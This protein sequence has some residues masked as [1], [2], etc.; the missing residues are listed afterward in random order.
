[1][2]ISL[3][4]R[5]LII[6]CSAPL[7]AVS[8]FYIDPNDVS[9]PT[10]SAPVIIMPDEITALINL[11]RSLDNVDRLIRSNAL[12]EAAAACD[13]AQGIIPNNPRSFYLMGTIGLARKDIP[14]AAHYF[15]KGLDY[16]S[17]F[18]PNYDG[19]GTVHR[20]TQDYHHA[21]LSYLTAYKIRTNSGYYLNLAGNLLLELG[22]TNGAGK[23]FFLGAS[24]SDPFCL[25]GLGI[26]ATN[27]L[28][29]L[30]NFQQANERYSQPAPG[31]SPALR[32][33]YVSGAER[34]LRL[35][36]DARFQAY[37]IVM[38]RELEKSNYT[39]A[40]ELGAQACVISDRPEARM[41]SARSFLGLSRTNDAISNLIQAVILSPELPEPRLALASLYEK[42]GHPHDA[43]DTLREGIRRIKT[44]ASLY[45]DLARLLAGVHAVTEADTVLRHAS[46]FGIPPR[47]ELNWAAIKKEKGDFTGAFSRL[48]NVY[49]TNNM[50]T[51]QMNASLHAMTNLANTHALLASN[52][53]HK[54]LGTIIHENYTGDEEQIRLHYIVSGLEGL[55]RSNEALNF[56]LSNTS[57]TKASMIVMSHL[58]PLFQ[59]TREQLKTVTIDGIDAAV[60]IPQ[61][62]EAWK[63]AYGSSS[64]AFQEY[65]EHMLM[66]GEYDA[67]IA[68]TAAASRNR[69]A[70]VSMKP[71]AARAYTALGI[72]AYYNNRSGDAREL[73]LKALSEDDSCHDARFF[74]NEVQAGTVIPLLRNA[75]SR[76]DLTNVIL[77]QKNLLELTPYDITPLV[78]LARAYLAVGDTAAAIRTARAIAGIYSDGSG[79]AIEG[80]ALFAVHDYY[81]A[82]KLYAAARAREPENA[83]YLMKTGRCYFELKRYPEALD[84]LFASINR[85]PTAERWFYYASTH[86]YLWNYTEAIDSMEKALEL[87]P[88]EA[89]YHMNYGIILFDAGRRENALTAFNRALAL[90]ATLEDASYY[91][92]RTLYYLNRI[93]E[94]HDLLQRLIAQKPKNPLYRFAVA[95]I[96]ET[97]A[98]M[99]FSSDVAEYINYAIVQLNTCIELCKRGRD[100]DLRQEALRKLKGLNPNFHVIATATLPAYASAQAAQNDTDRRIIYAPLSNGTVVAYNIIE[101][102]VLWE[103]KLRG[104]ASSPVLYALDHV[105]FGTDTGVFYILSAKTGKTVSRFETAG[106]ITE[107]PLLIPDASGSQKGVNMIALPSSDGRIYLIQYVESEERFNIQFLQMESAITTPLTYFLGHIIYGTATGGIYSLNSRTGQ[108]KWSF[109]AGGRFHAPLTAIDGYIYA[110]SDDG[111][112]YKLNADDGTTA[113]TYR[114]RGEGITE[115]VVTNG[116]CFFGDADGRFTVLDSS[117]NNVGYD[118]FNG[119]VIDGPV[120]FNDYIIIATGDGRVYFKSRTQGKDIDRLTL[121]DAV[122][123]K[124]FRLGPSVIGV[125]TRSG[126]FYIIVLRKPMPKEKL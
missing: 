35:M 11:N 16:D 60:Y 37:I 30:S 98:Q 38:R 69:D 57:G 62:Y 118:Q 22:D 121:H 106:A 42:E 94:S 104:V 82:L 14:T 125:L 43:I 4:T 29:A 20:I 76:G 71:Y 6:I 109:R 108:I 122:L 101:Q 102:R 64:N 3:L 51:V 72:D 31:L 126:V 111:M 80:D 123:Q 13:D 25:E 87:E 115:I 52:S 15:Q 18:L 21:L 114:H 50:R 34:T 40:A 59:A 56:V 8:S 44:N 1:M 120:F 113:A 12:D 2:D 92:A 54:A 86:Y 28:E 117:L 61:R 84:F 27:Q 48:A 103:V 73:F 100:D 119:A 75:E 58:N 89:Y 23:Y 32:E 9:V 68:F 85:Q 49:A 7:I 95:S 19:L 53:W 63:A 55:G 96:Y 33:R 78:P 93:D 110:A 66:A 124:P 26:L 10:N 45:F 99:L 36:N 46:R 88:S 105:M 107:P 91:R 79:P 112:L 39:R 67:L 97:K 65:G 24:L 70:P 90:D 5:A 77:Y 74:L 41:L 81:A 17:R 83:D 116:Y 47:L